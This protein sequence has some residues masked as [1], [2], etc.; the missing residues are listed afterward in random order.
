MAEP[1]SP[2]VM[3]LEGHEVV[4]AKDQPEYLPLPALRSEDGRV[5][6]RWELSDEER[7]MI[8]GGADVF[9]TVL[10]FNQALQPIVVEILNKAS[11]PRMIAAILGIDT[12][13]ATA[14][15]EV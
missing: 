8:A 15:P 14:D 7:E 9:V 12:V 13:S 11:D 6:S 10:T 5:M 1:K 3:G 2:V 4:Y